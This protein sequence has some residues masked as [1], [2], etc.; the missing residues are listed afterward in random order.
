LENVVGND[1]AQFVLS[2]AAQ[3]EFPKNIR[4]QNMEDMYKLFNLK[5]KVG[6]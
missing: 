2:L 3:G 4:V 1:S 6:E 5:E